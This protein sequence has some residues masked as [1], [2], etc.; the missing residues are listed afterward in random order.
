MENFHVNSEST[1]SDAETQINSSNQ[2]SHSIITR[3]TSNLQP[4]VDKL[5]QIL[6]QNTK[7]FQLACKQ[8][9]L[10]N[11]QIQALEHRFAQ[12]K[13]NG[14]KSLWYPLKLKI[15]SLEGVRNMFYTYS[16]MRAEEL[17]DLHQH[18]VESG[19]MQEMRL[20]D[21]Q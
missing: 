12:A 6:R 16:M 11:N 19:M 9:Q 20:E 5:I 14:M 7:K 2:G 15:S 21:L 8:V 13:V 17:D 4:N 18:L 10:L 3:D 1:F